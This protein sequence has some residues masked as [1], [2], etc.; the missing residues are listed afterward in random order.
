MKGIGIILVVL[1]HAIIVDSLPHRVIYLFHLSIFYF[2]SGFCYNQFYDTNVF[3]Y[4]R[5]RLIGLYKPFVIYGFAF[6][7]LHNLFVYIGFYREDDIYTF[8]DFVTKLPKLLL[9]SYYEPIVGVFW[10][11]KSLFVVTCS[12][13]MIRYIANYITPPPYLRICKT[14]INHSLTMELISFFVVMMFTFIGYLATNYSFA[15]HETLSELVLLPIFQAGFYARIFNLLRKSIVFILTALILLIIYSD[16]MVEINAKKFGDNIVYFYFA[17]LSGIYLTYCLSSFFLK[18]NKMKLFLVYI[19]NN[20]MSI[21]IWHFLFFR[22]CNIPI[23]IWMNDHH[24]VAHYYEHPVIY[25]APL[26]SIILYVL[27]GIMGPL[28][29]SF[30]FNKLRKAI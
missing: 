19:G 25:S 8:I 14:L 1:A 13:C 3:V 10:F 21:F 16:N 26:P 11:L 6:L 22:I 15:L 9:F 28:I 29:I 12:F 5:K 27:T 20:T 24:F 18:Q 4:F 7:L 17:A 30:I 23:S 2:C